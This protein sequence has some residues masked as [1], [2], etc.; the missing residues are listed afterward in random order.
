[1]GPTTGLANILVKNFHATPPTC[2]HL[3]AFGYSFVTL[4]AQLFSFAGLFFDYPQVSECEN[5]RGSRSPTMMEEDAAGVSTMGR[6]PLTAAEPKAG[7]AAVPL[8]A[9][10]PE[11]PLGPPRAG[12]AAGV[13]CK[14]FPAV[15]APSV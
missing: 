3:V 12:P 15:S 4:F 13:E 2:N 10:E 1:M 6:S 5:V 7:A 14:G 8:T 11:P 9:E